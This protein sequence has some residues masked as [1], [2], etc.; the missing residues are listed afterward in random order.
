MVQL[1]LDLSNNVGSIYLNTKYL[2]N[3]KE[4]QLNTE[5][6]QVLAPLSS[7]RV[8]LTDFIGAKLTSKDTISSHKTLTLKG[9]SYNSSTNK[10]SLK[11]KEQTVR[12]SSSSDS[13]D[14]QLTHWHAVCS[15]LISSH[16][17]K[18]PSS[19]LLPNPNQ[20]V[21]PLPPTPKLL[22]YLNPNAGNGKTL[23]KFSKV[24]PILDQLGHE[25]P[26]VLLIKT[27]R[28]NHAKKH[29]ESYP[30]GKLIEFDSILIVSGD[31]LMFEVIQGI[32]LRNPIEWKTIVQKLSLGIIP[33][34]SGNGLAVSLV[35]EVDTRLEIGI[36]QSTV[37]L[38][39]GLCKSHDERKRMDLC[40]MQFMGKANPKR[41]YSFLSMEWGLI[42]WCDI[43]SEKL[44]F[45]GGLRFAIYTVLGIIKRK[46][47]SGM[48]SYLPVASKGESIARTPDHPS[49]PQVPSY[50]ENFDLESQERNDA[51][52]VSFALLP[53]PDLEVPDNW[54]TVESDKF[55]DMWNVNMAWMAGDAQPGP[56]S[57]L[58]DGYMQISFNL[59]GRKNLLSYYLNVE[60][61]DLDRS[62]FLHAAP[63]RC[64]RFIPKEQ[65]GKRYI[66]V[67]GEKVEYKGF[68]VENLSKFLSVLG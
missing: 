30:L 65:K 61:P 45:L 16:R 68:Q 55:T 38:V 20:T 1:S 14:A 21:F 57:R 3:I 52:D 40:C 2:S 39:K 53:D 22:I 67:D 25:P 28:Q 12:I 4:L 50:W 34:G 60:N 46:R 43:E 32:M 36:K 42:S 31:G 44:R 29:I 27:N 33:A 18:T 13:L 66:C 5:K 59:G 8:N 54:I 41:I 10:K 48:I 9:Y 58:D 51:S 63:T 24:R 17:K 47:Y 23:S 37:V 64:Y 49:V 6:L 15:W 56:K 62:K 26:E 11:F 35:K 19:V 7:L